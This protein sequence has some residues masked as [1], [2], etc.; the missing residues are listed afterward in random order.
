MSK[1]LITQAKTLAEYDPPIFMLPVRLKLNDGKLDKVPTLSWKEPVPFRELL[2][3]LKGTNALG[4]DLGKSGLVTLDVDS[5]KDECNFDAFIEEHDLEIPYTWKIKSGSGGTHYI[6]ANPNDL[7]FRGK[8]PGVEAVDIKSHGGYSVAPPSKLKDRVYEWIVG[9]DELEEGPA[10]VPQWLFEWAGKDGTAGDMGENLRLKAAARDFQENIE[11]LDQLAAAPNTLNDREEWLKIAFGLFFEFQDTPE[12]GR[13]RD[14]FL[15]WSAKWDDS[16]KAVENAVTTWDSLPRIAELTTDNPATI[17]SVVRYLQENPTPKTDEEIAEIKE[18]VAEL[19]KKKVEET[20]FTIKFDALKNIPPRQWVHGTDALKGEVTMIPAP[21]GV[22]KSSTLLVMLLSMAT[23]RSLLGRETYG[24]HKVMLWSGE[25]GRVEINRRLLAAMKHYN[26]TSEDIGDRLHVVTHDDLPLTMAQEHQGQQAAGQ[27]TIGIN[28]TDVDYLIG[29]MVSNGIEIASFDPL[30][31]AHQLDENSNAHAHVVMQ[32]FKRVALMADAAIILVHHVGK[33]SLRDDSKG[34]PADAARGAT[35]FINAA[36]VSIALK[37]MSLADAGSFRIDNPSDYAEIIDAKANLSRRGVGGQRWIEKVSINI[38]NGTAI[39]PHGDDVGV[40]QKWTPT[41]EMKLSLAEN[42]MTV[43][44]A[45]MDEHEKHA[46]IG[47]GFIFQHEQNS[48]WA[49]KRLSKALKLPIG[50]ETSADRR[51][52]EENENRR[53]IRSYLTELMG[54]G[55]M[56]LEDREKP[57]NRHMGPAYVV[58]ASYK[59][60]LLDQIKELKKAGVKV[61]HLAP[62]RG[63]NAPPK[64]GKVAQRGAKKGS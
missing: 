26:I 29:Y 8:I 1:L 6:F 30:V 20:D 28:K 34:D 5:Y 50:E 41:A 16:E 23:G 60:D 53:V 9:P 21:G 59:F 47:A 10:M 35:A 32:A 55:G 46:D 42:L 61:R 56:H 44:T 54:H 2:R 19:T 36:R 40:V 31:E 24:K 22:G 7:R 25:D 45:L 38:G 39:Y 58:D 57:G 3:S 51:S 49:G 17:A 15:S 64:G 12:E 48:H 18:T 14:V 27:P 11:V 52:D 33:G 62:P 4:I 43:V 63:K 37:Q 13:A